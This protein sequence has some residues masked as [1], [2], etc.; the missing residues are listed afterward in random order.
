MK[1]FL[2]TL[3][4]VHVFCRNNDIKNMLILCDFFARHFTWNDQT[5]KKNGSL[6]YDEINQF[7][8]EII[9]TNV[10]TFKSRNG[11]S[12]IG[13]CIGTKK[14]A[15]MNVF[16]SVD[17]TVELFTG[18]PI[19]GHFPVTWNWNLLSDRENLKFS[20][21]DL[22]HTS[23]L[24]WANQLESLCLKNQQLSMS[25]DAGEVWLGLKS[26]FSSNKTAVLKKKVVTN[27]S[28][29]FWTPYLSSLSNE[30]RAARKLFQ[31]R[32]ND[33]NLSKFCEA[34]KTFM[35][36]LDKARNYWIEANLD[37]LNKSSAS[38]FWMQYQRTVLEKEKNSIGPL[39]DEKAYYSVTSRRK[40]NY[41]RSVSSLVSI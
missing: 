16:C 15:R 4:A 40:P 20:T 33:S 27:H 41:Y 21:W 23:W 30:L 35:S 22:A 3:E 28:K 39:N 37:L 17:T 13:F 26:I 8:L 38:K 5:T 7:A 10:P 1:V 6:F 2:Q 9:A 32:N 29:P 11:E 24:Y 18:A 31:H 36:E 14:V 25:D 34:K 19:Q 12:T